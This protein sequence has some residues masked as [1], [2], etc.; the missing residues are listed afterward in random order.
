MDVRRKFIADCVERY[1]NTYRGQYE[2]F[3][4]IIH[5]RRG[6]LDD[7]KFAELRDSKEIRVA[8]SLPEK[9]YQMIFIG[10]DGVNAKKFLEEKGE[11]K[12]FSKK[13]PQYLVPNEY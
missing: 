11:E 10:L 5:D 1:Q 13:F 12:W 2:E 7:K 6:N 3:L 8:I 4:H 9:L